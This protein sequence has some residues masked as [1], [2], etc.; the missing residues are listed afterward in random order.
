MVE[1]VSGEGRL[2][3]MVFSAEEA[4]RIA[5]THPNVYVY[6]VPEGY[7]YPCLSCWEDVS[8]PH[9]CPKEASHGG[10]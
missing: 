4:H 9:V 8:H 10:G 6:D 5:A 2:I 7:P 1:G 3:R